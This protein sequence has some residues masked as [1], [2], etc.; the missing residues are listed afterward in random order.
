MYQIKHIVLSG[1]V[2]ENIFLLESIYNKLKDKDF[3]V[4]FN[5]QIPINDSG[6]SIGQMAIA[7]EKLRE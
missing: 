4:F 6:I 7:I 3:Y 5:E 1:G 2:F